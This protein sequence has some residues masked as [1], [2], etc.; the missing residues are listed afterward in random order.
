MD[1]ESPEIIGKEAPEI[2]PK[3]MTE[4]LDS[5]V[6]AVVSEENKPPLSDEEKEKKQEYY[7]DPFEQE[8][9]MKAKLAEIENKKKFG[10][11][12]EDDNKPVA[13]APGI[14]ET[15][16][17][18]MNVTGYFSAG[19]TAK[20]RSDIM[21]RPTS[22]KTAK[23]CFILSVISI[24]LSAIFLLTLFITSF[25]AHWFFNWTYLIALALSVIT[26]FFAIRSRNSADPE[27]IRYALLN[28]VLSSITVI[29]LLVVI[30]N[31]IFKFI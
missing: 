11:P 29:P 5:A 15:I 21:R 2:A 6:K 4:E 26:A 17:P 24:F 22:R 8:E 19:E 13:Q 16:R 12:S 28:L 10:P 3:N 9:K 25:S 1:K 27:T 20:K 14:T 7:V 18:D 31:S 23:R 30:L